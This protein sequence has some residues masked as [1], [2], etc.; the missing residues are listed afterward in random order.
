MDFGVIGAV[1]ST[2]IANAYDYSDPAVFEKIKAETGIE[3]QHYYALPKC[4]RAFQG[5]HCLPTAYV[6]A[7]EK[8][9]PYISLWKAEK[10]VNDG[11][12]RKAEEL[13]KQIDKT[14][15]GMSRVKWLLAKNLFF[16]SDQMPEDA[17]DEKDRFLTEGVGYARECL[18]IAPDDINCQ[19]NLATLLGRW[20]TN[21]G[22]LK[23]AFN[24]EEVRDAMLK[25]STTDQHYR[26]PS[27]NTARGAS[28]Y[29]LGIFFRLAPDS[30]FIELFFGVRGNVDTSIAYFQKARTTKTDQIEL[31]TEL[32]ASQFCKAE[33]DDSAEAASDARQSI[34]VCQSIKAKS[35]IDKI[36]QGDCARLLADPSLGCGYSR[37]R[38]QETDVEK[39]KELKQ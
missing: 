24:A 30:F 3:Y 29:A 16:R 21:Q 2:L 1:L 19:L 32:A 34:A 36:S 17:I 14:H 33:R 23:G 11:L 9:E 8:G 15:P 25:A 6:D 10:M 26:Y 39:F 27:G 22:I 28:Y 31:Y 18:E 20:S 12:D 37:D 13:L 35:G 7:V 38:Q 4:I 5:D